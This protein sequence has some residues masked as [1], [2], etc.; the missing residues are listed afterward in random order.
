M[1]NLTPAIYDGTTT[2]L[3]RNRAYL[4]LRDKLKLLLFNIAYLHNTNQTN[5]MP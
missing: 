1:Y 3:F 4:N 2:A 5:F